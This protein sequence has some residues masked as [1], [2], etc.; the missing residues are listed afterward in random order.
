MPLHVC[1]LCHEYPPE[2]H[3][4]VGTVVQSLARA[5]V[6]RG[7]RVTVLGISRERPGDAD[8]RGVLVRRLPHTRVRGT[9]FVVHG[10]RLRRALADVH[11]EH[12]IDVVE[13]QEASLAVLPRRRPYATVIRM[14]GGHHFFAVTLGGRPRAW[15]SWLER[16]SFARADHLSAVSRY[17]GE[18][19]RSLL[20]LGARPIEVLPNGVDTEAFRPRDAPEA[21]GTI[22]FVGTL[23]EKKGIRQLVEAMPAILA[24][25]PEAR[26]LAAG[27]D[28]VDDQGSF[29]ARLEVALDRATADHVEFLG[30]V[31]H[32]E[33]PGLL[34]SASVCAYPSHMEAMPLAWLEALAMGRPVVAGD[35]GPAPE[36]VE[37][38]VTGGLCDPHDPAAIAAAVADLLDDPERRA[39]LGRAARARVEADFSIEVLAARN[40]AFFARCAAHRRPAGA[41]G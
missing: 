37:D 26:L 18:T 41:S 19:T 4:G 17:V 11:R 32:Q 24:R 33:V 40:E 34:A 10:R 38:G 5:L 35:I 21:P 3:G 9:G 7:H 15:R 22:A 13:G 30:P 16:R 20:G 12:A 29:R 8:D 31:D 28:W 25:H 14:N 36:V 6:A 27:R 23:C 2:P 1:F 39:R